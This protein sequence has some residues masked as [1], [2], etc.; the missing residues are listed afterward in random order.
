MQ[1]HQQEPSPWWADHSLLTGSL[2]HNACMVRREC[3]F[4]V[5]IAAK[6]EGS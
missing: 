3:M 1:S 4:Q 2:L 5:P 6:V